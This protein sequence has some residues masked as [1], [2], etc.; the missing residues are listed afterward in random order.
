MSM[1]ID[2]HAVAEELIDAYEAGDLLPE[3]LSSREGFDLSTAYAVEAELSR[4]RRAA[5]W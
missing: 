4:R 5:C 1:S 2:P 3:T